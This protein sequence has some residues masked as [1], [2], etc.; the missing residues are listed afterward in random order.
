MDFKGTTGVYE[1]IYC[2]SSK[3]VRK[4]E[5]VIYE[6]RATFHDLFQFSMTLAITILFWGNSIQQITL[7]SPPKCVPFSKSCFVLVCPCFGVCTN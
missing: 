1:H 2:Y 3:L 5:R 7:K 4:K 6:F